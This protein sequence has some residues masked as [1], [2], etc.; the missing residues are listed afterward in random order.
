MIGRAALLNPSVPPETF[1]CV[2][3]T[4][5]PQEV[6]PKPTGGTPIAAGHLP[7]AVVHELAAMNLG[8]STNGT[9]ALGS[10]LLADL[11][12]SDDVQIPLR[13]D[14]LQVIE[15]AATPTDHHQQTSP[16]GVVLGVRAQMLGELANS[17]G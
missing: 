17:R 16:T 5:V 8:P 12:T 11:E 1:C 13:S 3:Q 14:P 15:Q 7:L 10:G 4:V 6:G 2:P 9:W